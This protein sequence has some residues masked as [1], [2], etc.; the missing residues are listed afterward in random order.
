MVEILRGYS[1]ACSALAEE[2]KR[3]AFEKAVGFAHIILPV[4]NIAN[5]T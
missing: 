2:V 4:K 3:E 5:K 1:D